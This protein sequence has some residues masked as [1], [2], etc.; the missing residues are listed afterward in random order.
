[1]RELASLV[2]GVVV[3]VVLSGRVKIW[4][5]MVARIASDISYFMRREWSGEEVDNDIRIY[6]KED[7]YRN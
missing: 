6:S 1:M 2:Y 3:N 5:I 4:K 7:R